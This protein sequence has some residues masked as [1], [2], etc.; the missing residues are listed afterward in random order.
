MADF[1]ENSMRGMMKSDYGDNKLDKDLELNR[2]M[3]ISKKGKDE[4][5]SK[6]QNIGGNE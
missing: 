3:S 1:R 6:L 5:S 2:D 4:Y